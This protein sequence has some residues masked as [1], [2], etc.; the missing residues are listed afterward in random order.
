[1]VEWMAGSGAIT[2]FRAG[3]GVVLS[4]TVAVSASD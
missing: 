2:G 4:N 3:F 1:M